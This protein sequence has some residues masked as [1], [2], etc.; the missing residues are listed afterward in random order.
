MK[1]GN[2][3]KKK[4][5][6]KRQSLTGYGFDPEELHS[7]RSLAD[8]SPRD[9]KDSDMAE[10]QQFHFHFTWYVSFQFCQSAFDY[11]YSDV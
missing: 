4:K 5:K 2:L 3:F 11:L 7:Q 6:K 1:V 10:Q 9:Q 8:Y